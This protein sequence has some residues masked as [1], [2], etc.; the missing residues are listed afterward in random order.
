MC[1][2]VLGI[3]ARIKG[4]LRRDNNKPAKVERTQIKEMPSDTLVL[5]NKAQMVVNPGEDKIYRA[6]GQSEFEALL[7]GDTIFSSGYVTNNPKGWMGTDWNT[8][9]HCES[10][11]C[12]FVTFKNE[13]LPFVG[14]R[15]FWNDPRLGVNGY[16][17]DNVENIRKG[18]NVHGKLV[19]ARNFKDAQLHDRKLKFEDIRANL[20]ILARNKDEVLRRE[21]WD[22][23]TSYVK[24]F[25]KIVKDSLPFVHLKSAED[26]KNYAILICE[27]DKKENMT[28]L[29][30][31]IKNFIKSDVFPP[32][33]ISLYIGKHGSSEDIP[34]LIDLLNKFSY[35]D[36]ME[37][38]AL[39]LGKTIS[40]LSDGNIQTNKLIFKS[41]LSVNPTKLNVLSTYFTAFN[42]DGSKIGVFRKIL[43]KCKPLSTACADNLNYNMAV[44]R[45][46]SEL[47]KFGD[48]SDIMLLEHFIDKA[49]PQQCPSDAVYKAINSIV[50]RFR[51][52]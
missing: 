50:K 16:T 21:A 15:D 29:H 35:H 40:T 26:L 48:M 52:I 30:D 20:R 33:V 10:N 19:F 23:L 14:S 36:K 5:S 39:N 6:I 28:L 3:S 2:H 38:Q 13:N 46:A 7:R 31:V 37:Y 9:F 11:E 25:P 1:M 24:E 42:S 49:N 47:A 43:G 18:F 41:L 32:H 12:Y 17:I 45:C 4:I 44:T 34:I 27:S 51:A 22:N 8:G